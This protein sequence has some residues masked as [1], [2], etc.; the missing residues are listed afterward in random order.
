MSHPYPPP[1]GHHGGYPP[2]GWQPPIQPRKR[3]KW[4]WIVG[5]PFGLLV[6]LIVVAALSGSRQPQPA[7]T[8]AAGQS[9]RSEFAFGDTADLDGLQITVTA[10]TRQK[11]FG[12]PLL[13]AMVTYQN[14]SGD[15]QRFNGGFDWK[16]QSPDGVAKLPTFGGENTLSA[17]E[18]APG[19]TVRGNVCVADPKLS[20]EYTVILDQALSLQ[21]SVR[22]KGSV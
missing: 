10:P 9:D 6:L 3:R 15:T 14:G 18:L 17:G 5:I 11:S 22:W 7:G 4:P 16:I 2:P 8:G 21:S 20:G 1:P 13:C 19:G 12:R